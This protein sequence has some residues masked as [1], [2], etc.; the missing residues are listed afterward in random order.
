MK[1]FLIAA[2]SIFTFSSPL[3]AQTKELSKQPIKGSTEVNVRNINPDSDKKLEFG[4]NQSISTQDLNNI[5]TLQLGWREIDG[6]DVTSTQYQIQTKSK[7]RL[8]A[9]FGMD[10]IKNAEDQLKGSLQISGPLDAN[11]NISGSINVNRS[12]FLSSKKSIEQEY[13]QTSSRANLQVR[14]SPETTFNAS[15]SKQW[16]SDGNEI[17]RTSVDLNQKINK[18]IYVKPG[19]GWSSYSFKTKEY[20]SKNQFNAGVEIG[21]RFPLSETLGMQIGIR[22]TFI[23]EQD[24]EN[25]FRIGGGFGLRYNPNKTNSFEASFIGTGT[26]INSTVRYNYNF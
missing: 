3:L 4:I 5:H 8:S 11:N 18:V 7:T 25:K 22:P 10:F 14:L 12:A 19:L 1:S 17:D 2:L 24:K 26:G 9:T 16:V 13:T 6:V 15:Y 23:Q 20:T 21:A